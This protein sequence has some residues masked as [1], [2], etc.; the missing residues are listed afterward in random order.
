MRREQT[1]RKGR[2]EGCGDCFGVNPLIKQLLWPHSWLSL[3]S[4]PPLVL[5]Q[6]GGEMC[7]SNLV[8]GG[9][10]GFRVWL[11]AQFTREVQGQVRPIGTSL[12]KQQLLYCFE[13]FSIWKNREEQLLSESLLSQAYEFQN[14]LY[15]LHCFPNTGLFQASLH[16]DCSDVG[17]QFWQVMQL[18]EKAL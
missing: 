5:L 7:R 16:T 15:F 10:C 4:Q 9:G 14:L 2:K 17:K 12:G 6:G 18:W 8:M 1:G 11:E 3:C 13:C